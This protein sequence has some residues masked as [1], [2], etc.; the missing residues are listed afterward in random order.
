MS[1]IATLSRGI[2][3]VRGTSGDDRVIV[4][5]HNANL[6]PEDVLDLGAGLDVLVM[7]R[8]GYVGTGAF[9]LAGARGL[10]RIE[11][12]AADEVRFSGDDALL[13]QSDSGIVTLAFGAAPMFLDLREMA[14]SRAGYVLE[15]TGTVTLAD[16]RQTVTVADGVA[17]RVRGG[18][19]AD[20][21]L[22]GTGNDTL[23]GNAGSDLLRGGRGDDRL[24]GGD[25]HDELW[26][27]AGNDTLAGGRGYDRLG[28]GTGQDVLSG[29]SAS[30]VFVIAPGAD[31]RITDFDPSDPYEKIDLRAFSE[32]GADDLSITAESGGARVDLGGRGVLHL[33]GVAPEALGLDSF[34]LP[35]ERMVS[36]A[37]T[38][39]RDAD[40]LFTDGTDRFA[41]TS[42]DEVF[43]LR[44]SFSKLSSEDRFEGRGGTD[45]L[46]LNGEDRSI[47]I[48]RL[49]GMSGIDVIDLTA[50]SGSHRI[51]VDPQMLTQSD[52][53][54]LLL[55][56]GHG[57]VALD[58][59]AAPGAVT[60][61]STGLVSLRSAEG[62]AV[63]ISDLVGGRVTGGDGD[64]RIDGGRR[65]DRIDG[66]IGDDTITGGGG[67]D[68]LIGG[69]G[70]DRFLPGAGDVTI[71]GGDGHD[72]I[73]LRPGDGR[74]TVTDFD[75]TDYLERIDISALTGIRKPADVTLKIVGRDV[76]LTGPELDL[77]LEG[78]AGRH[79]GLDDFL[80]AGQ[81]ADRFSVGP[82]APLSAL[83]SLIEDAPDHSVIRLAPGTYDFTESL[84]I[85][86][87]HITIRG[88]GEDRTVL[89]N[90]IADRDV[91]NAEAHA[92]LVQPHDMETK[93]GM[94]AA[95]A[96]AGTR[97]VWLTSGHGLEKGDLLFI[98]QPNSAEWLAETGN[99]GWA[100]L[101]PGPGNEQALWLREIRSRVV[102][103]DGDRVTLEDPLPYDFFAGQAQAQHSTF[104]TDIH[105]SD[106]TIQGRWGTPDRYHF[107]NT[108][109]PWDHTTG[110]ELD[111][112]Q[113][114]TVSRITTVNLPSHA[115]RFQRT[116]D[117]TGD[118][119]TAIGAFNKA[120]SNG[121]HFTLSESF[122]TVL[123]NITSIGA[124]HAV[125]FSSYS[126]EHYNDIHVSF[127]DRDINFHG[128]PDADNTVLVD[129]M[130]M[131]YPVAVFPQWRA[132][133]PGGFPLHP[134]ATIEAN[135]VTFRYAETG[136]R[137][138][139]VTGHDSG[140][141]LSTGMGNDSLTGGRSDDILIGGTEGD[142]LIGR[143]GSDTFVW[144]PGD[145]TDRILDFQAGA[146]GDRL[147]LVGTG[148]T[149][150][151]QISLVQA[152][153][154]TLV[155]L[156]TY[157]EIRLP[158]IAPG[159]LTAENFALAD[160]PPAG[161]PDLP[162]RIPGLN[163]AAKAS[164]D[165]L[166]GTSG[167]DK[168][169]IQGHHLEMP[170]FQLA[171]GA[172]DDTVVLGVDRFSGALHK[173]GRYDGVDT[174]DVAGLER[175]DMVIS[176]S[177][178]AQSDAGELTLRVGDAG[179]ALAL[180]A[181][182]LR[183]GD[184]LVIDG[185]REV[186]LADGVSHRIETGDRIGG[187]VTGGDGHD[188][189]TGGDG[190]DRLTGGHGRDRLA[191]GAGNDRLTGGTGADDF[192]FDLP[193][194]GFRGIDRIVDFVPGQD[195]VLFDIPAGLFPSGQI[196]RSVFSDSG[197]AETPGQM[198]IY[199][200]QTGRLSIDVDGS[201]PGGARA[202]ALFEGAP[203]LGH[204][205]IYLI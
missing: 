48:A 14:A 180:S 108:M 67:R 65:S 36:L 107:G 143:G 16:I 172:G 99:T 128:S 80:V 4:P 81:A 52:D 184:R 192:V 47:S 94:L 57:D 198:V 141:I 202:I 97:T 19:L 78:A 178:I 123:K 83:Q 161:I 176:R 163:L 132:V 135:D 168:I 1:I 75:T 120:G 15:G 59:S 121:V 150:A 157:G 137:K 42:A 32:I 165:F 191:G 181:P 93:V 187:R 203:D 95:D 35:G 60:V 115:F 5:A 177:M 13:A 186:R 122:S 24:E 109:D 82:G 89:R 25:R 154:Q 118:D 74:V 130:V 195:R 96:A 69:A 68:T 171:V 88:A 179:G 111:G 183:S 185:A 28:G 158:G 149:D 156:G 17:G 39:G 189:L 8:T 119:L 63:T 58:S 100:P 20:T 64:D 90:M 127:T 145:G 49:E 11:M 166:M 10:D 37:E 193:G 9:K 85:D 38:L 21:L 30:D 103:V 44:G 136:D 201:G 6:V 126:A 77:V 175:M 61:E 27:G 204:D 113:D 182:G 105:L 86:R 144:M 124:R 146:G 53:G 104:L 40:H 117:V 152:D 169:H 194:D 138:D 139:I 116:H 162:E 66:G 188:R 72:V 12:T 87:S 142:T 148:Y 84:R 54:Q 2:D 140:S 70:D 200:R 101:D 34:V 170:D 98:N 56:L 79:F 205:D 155:R 73:V 43:E 51:V 173:T 174:F 190:H 7:E 151:G 102:S 55:R 23:L 22:G 197:V 76:Y 92:F 164:F 110:L 41:G 147:M 112:V 71:T 33:T 167:R 91:G 199:D 45:T 159:A 134:R 29:G 106:F 160:A 196:S 26:G 50:A 3:T 133:S 114:S 125:E 62:Q 31:T 129:R 131:D 46:R 153:G 18:M